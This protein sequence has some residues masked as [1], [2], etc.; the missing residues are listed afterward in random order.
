MTD[1][2]GPAAPC[3][4]ITIPISHY[5]EKARWALE[6]SAIPYTERAHLQ[7]IHWAAV[8][9]A[10]GGMTVP[11]LVCGDRV[12]RE[13]ADIVA[14]ADSHA[15]PERRLYPEDSTEVREL[16]R[17]FDERLGPHGR[18]WMYNELRGHTALVREYG[19]TGVPAW[20]RRALPLA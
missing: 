16:E 3:V 19:T 13:S 2:D 20:Q 7:V 9:R 6:R 15:S 4:L 8:K 11:V 14:F 18:R 17:D 5:C 10:G 12:L 1:G